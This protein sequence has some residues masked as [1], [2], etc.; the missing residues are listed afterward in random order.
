MEI[1][2]GEEENSATKESCD[3][4]ST[5]FEENS[6]AESVENGQE[7]SNLSNEVYNTSGK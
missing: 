7:L 3:Q 1:N 2:E 4:Q 5:A 6:F